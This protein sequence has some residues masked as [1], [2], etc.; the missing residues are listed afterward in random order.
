MRMIGSSFQS[1]HTFA[2]IKHFVTD[3]TLEM[4]IHA[5][6]LSCLD[7]CNSLYCGISKTQIAPLQLVQNDAARFL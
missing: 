1:L 2:K 7:Y 4:A 3:K 5:F 6:F